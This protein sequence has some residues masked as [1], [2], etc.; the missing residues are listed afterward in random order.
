[1]EKDS[2]LKG[3]YDA[4]ICSEVIE[5]LKNW[6]NAIYILRGRLNKEGKIIFTTQSGK[7]YPH[8]IEIGHIKHFEP[9]EI[10]NQL[11]KANFDV[12]VAK[13][14][15]W[16]FMNVK[17]FL[18]SRFL[19][20]SNLKKEKVSIPQKAVYG[21]F[22]YLYLLSILPGPQIIVIAKQK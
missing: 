18:V 7:R 13:K 15:G 11:I 5:H 8:H 9:E 20:V 21:I 6:Q 2:K 19:R 12:V 14:I 10:T 22:Y 4:I 1:M 16:P 17:N 3:Y